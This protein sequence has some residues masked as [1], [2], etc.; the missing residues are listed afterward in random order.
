MIKLKGRFILQIKMKI[1][2]KEIVV[3]DNR[4]GINYE[5]PES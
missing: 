4:Y 3:N 2:R 5:I 1:Y